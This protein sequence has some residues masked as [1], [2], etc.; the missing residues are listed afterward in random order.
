MTFKRVG[1]VPVVKER[2]NNFSGFESYLNIFLSGKTCF[3][4]GDLNLNL[5]DYQRNA[6]VRDFV[7]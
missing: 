1:K 4:V 6:K 7:N 3:I 2:I 5:I